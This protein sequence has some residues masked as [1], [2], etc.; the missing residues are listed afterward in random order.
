MGK[1][2]NRKMEFKRFTVHDDKCAMKI[3]TDAVLLGALAEHP[4]PK[5][6]VDVGTGSGIVA[7]MLAQ[8]YPDAFID[9]IELNKE[10]A[11]QASDNFAN[12]P[13][14]DRLKCH[15]MSYQD[16]SDENRD[17]FQADLIVSN[18]PFF[19]GTSKSPDE[20]RNMARHQDYLPP[21]EFLKRSM[22]MVNK[23]AGR[24][25]FV[26][27]THRETEVMTIAD[28]LGM[29][30]NGAYRIKA[31]ENHDVV[32]MVTIYSHQSIDSADW[33]DQTIVLENGVGN[34]REFTPEYL[35]LM[36]GF[37]LKA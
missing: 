37:F 8:R 32:R 20:A 28:R 34:N 26:W 2:Q 10:A 29:F 31:T 30:Y 24:V 36:K 9:A 13:F 27:P 16:W 1:S 25:V 3:G 35:K 14:S 19:D 23:E 6:I 21:L 11:D 4:N 22:W 15:N 5:R 17:K 33:V 7:L 18:P 12:S